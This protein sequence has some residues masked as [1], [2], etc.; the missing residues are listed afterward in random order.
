MLEIKINGIFYWDDSSENESDHHFVDLPPVTLKLEHSLVSISKWE[1][2]WKKPYLQEGVRTDRKEILD[3]I[4]C[5]TLNYREIKAI[6]DKLREAD[7]SIEEDVYYNLLNSEQ[8]EKIQNYIDDSM[9]AT[10]FTNRE[11]KF[12]KKEIVTSEVIY[13]WL[14]ALQI[15]FE[16]QYWHLNRLIT[17][18]NVVNDKNTPKKKRSRADVLKEQYKQNEARLAKYGTTG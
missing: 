6:E 15:P 7:D 14:V 12:G 1:A 10:W 8:H 3:Y 16:V 13:S 18:V 17:L 11:K 2:K 4:K 9:T 5:M